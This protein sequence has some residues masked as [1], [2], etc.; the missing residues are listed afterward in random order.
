MFAVDCSVKSKEVK[1]YQKLL[2]Q[3]IAFNY[4]TD[5]VVRYNVGGLHKYLTRL[6]FFLFLKYQGDLKISLHWTSRYFFFGKY[7]H[8]NDTSSS[9]VPPYE[10]NISLFGVPII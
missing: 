2:H 9:R 5:K 1:N 7:V 8:V 6:V 10:G 3:L 4:F